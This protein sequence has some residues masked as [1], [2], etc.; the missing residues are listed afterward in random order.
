[1]LDVPSS[2]QCF[3]F[4]P[5]TLVQKHLGDQCYSG[6]RLEHLA[7]GF[8]QAGSTHTDELSFKVSCKKSSSC[9]FVAFPAT[10]DTTTMIELFK[11]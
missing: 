3:P 7:Y 11:I 6:S 9:F 5:V 4:F 10:V 1:M 8:L 2:C